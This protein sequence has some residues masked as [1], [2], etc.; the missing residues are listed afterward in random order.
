MLELSPSETILRCQG[1]RS[2]PRAHRC[3]DLG[4]HRR[5]SREDGR[6]GHRGE[7]PPRPSPREDNTPRNRLARPVELGLGPER[8]DMDAFREPAHHVFVLSE[9]RELHR[10]RP[11]RHPAMELANRQLPLRPVVRQP[12]RDVV[13]RWK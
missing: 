1:G 12:R 11:A 2:R 7:G 6:S 3:P 9:D 13:S 10:R 4:V 8:E 5:S